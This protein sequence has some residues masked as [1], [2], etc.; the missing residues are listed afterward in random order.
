[1][2]LVE[3]LTT[4]ENGYAISGLLNYGDYKLKEL[5]PAEGYLPTNQEWDIQIREDG[6]VYTYDITN[7]VIKGKIQIVKIDAQN[8]EKPV[9]GA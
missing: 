1:G 7:D 6:K 2:A 9:S 8:A 3:E 5:K 4:N